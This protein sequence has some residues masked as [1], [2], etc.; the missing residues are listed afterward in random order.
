MLAEIARQP[1]V[2]AA[3]GGLAL[4]DLPVT[5]TVP[6]ISL[7]RGRAAT[8]PASPQHIHRRRGRHGGRHLGSLGSGKVTSGSTLTPA[9][10]GADDAV[11]D[12]GY[13]AQYKLSTGGTIDVGGTGFRITGIVAAPQGV[14]PP[15]VYIPLAKAQQIG[16]NGQSSLIHKVDTI[17]VTAASAADTSAVQAEISSCCLRPPS[18]ISD[19]ASEVTGSL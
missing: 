17:Y 15:D 14:D 10:A 11:V 19:L 3:V 1:N 18:P 12:S 2:T 8:S 6:Q 9:E 5:G 13:A 7:A 4:S 16:K